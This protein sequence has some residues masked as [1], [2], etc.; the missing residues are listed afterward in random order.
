[1]VGMAIC[2]LPRVPENVGHILSVFNMGKK[3]HLVLHVQMIVC[4]SLFDIFIAMRHLTKTYLHRNSASDRD[5][6]HSMV[7]SSLYNIYTLYNNSGQPV[8]KEPA[9][10]SKSNKITALSTHARSVNCD[11]QGLW[12]APTAAM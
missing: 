12:H 10:T 9:V 6:I 11:M 7:K 1:M 4:H 5:T 2:Y 8:L 3:V